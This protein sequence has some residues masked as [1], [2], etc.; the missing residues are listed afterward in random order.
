[1]RALAK[2]SLSDF[3]GTMLEKIVPL[4]DL[5]LLRNPH[6]SNLKKAEQTRDDFHQYMNYWRRNGLLPFIEKGKWGKLSFVQVIW[7][8][9]LESMRE[10]GL[11]L[12]L[13]KNVCDYFFRDAY[14]DNVAKIN[15]SN[16]KKLLEE[17]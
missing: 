12:D 1:M 4:T 7:V 11:S 10:L 15:L 8:Q 9:I 17:K 13:M 14:N 6:V 3:P 2:I 5:H 16:S